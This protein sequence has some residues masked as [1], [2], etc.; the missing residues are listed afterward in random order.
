ML[1]SLQR[2]E[3]LLETLITPMTGGGDGVRADVSPL[4]LRSSP[5]LGWRRPPLPTNGAHGRH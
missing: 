5:T 1:A 4:P 2:I 3:A